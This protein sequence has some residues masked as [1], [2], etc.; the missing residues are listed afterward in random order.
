MQGQSQDALTLRITSPVAD[1]VS[2]YASVIDNATQD[3]IYIQAVAA[4]S[5]QELTVPVIGRAPGA[6]GTFWRSDVTFF[7]PTADRLVLTLRYGSTT[8]TLALGGR[9]TEILADIVSSFNQSSGS[10][11]LLVSWEGSAGPVVTSR[12]YTTSESGGT[13][14][15][16]IDPMGELRSAMYVPGLRNDSSFRSYLGV[17]NGGDESEN[18]TFILL[19]PSGNE[20]ARSTVN[21]AARTQVQYSVSA[22]F[23]NVNASA[24]TLAV[25]GDANA[26]LFAYGSMVDNASGDP[27]FFAGQ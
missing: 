13:F 14:G 26:R 8:R 27:V 12:T 11:A 25:E 6:N 23:P 24:F 15:Q 4:P 22:L 9:D 20:L 21:V 16:S 1:A 18:V 7:N 10:G 3:P 19:Y 2:A 17:V 5:G